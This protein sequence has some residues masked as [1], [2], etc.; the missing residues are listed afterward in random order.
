[1]SPHGSSPGPRGPSSIVQLS[2]PTLSRHFPYD[3]RPATIA[4]HAV[5]MVGDSITFDK[6]HK[7]ILNFCRCYKIAS[8]LLSLSMPSTQEPS[9]HTC[10]VSRIRRNCSSWQL[11]KVGRL[12]GLT[13]L[14]QLLHQA[15]CVLSAQP[16]T[17]DHSAVFR[18][19]SVS[20]DSQQYCQ[21]EN[22]AEHAEKLCFQ[23]GASALMVMRSSLHLNYRGDDSAVHAIERVREVELKQKRLAVVYNGNHDFVFMENTTRGW[24]GLRCLTSKLSSRESGDGRLD[25]DP[26]E[27]TAA[28]VFPLPEH[29]SGVYN[30]WTRS[31]GRED[32][33]WGA[34]P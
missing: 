15:G 3:I 32:R 17:K 6:A 19:S 13:F 4:G 24:G 29:Y 14:L 11:E 16:V 31:A 18:L 22:Q 23:S 10:S 12:L 20:D 25:V 7:P 8:A 21:H 33:C 30:I 5:C 9:Q 27:T 26:L 1:L 34:A 28:R 2:L